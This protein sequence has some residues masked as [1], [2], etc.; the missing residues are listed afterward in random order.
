MPPKAKFTR[1]EITAAALELAAEKGIA[2]LTTRKL[3]SERNSGYAQPRIC[4][5]A[6]TDSIGQSQSRYNHAPKAVKRREF[7]RTIRTA[8]RKKEALMNDTVNQNGADGS[9]F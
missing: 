6:D 5:N 9:V 1:E 2:S 3:P 4:S 7:A 8:K